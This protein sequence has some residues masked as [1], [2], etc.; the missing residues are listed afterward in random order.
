MV[1]RAQL[2][3]LFSRIRVV[4]PG[5]SSIRTPAER[6]SL[7]RRF[8]TFGRASWGT[9]SERVMLGVTHACGRILPWPIEIWRVDAEVVPVL[10][11][12]ITALPVL[13]IASKLYPMPSD[14]LHGGEEEGPIG[15]DLVVRFDEGQGLFAKVHRCG[16]RQA[17][18]REVPSLD[19]SQA[20]LLFLLRRVGRHVA[21][22]VAVYRRALPAAPHE[23]HVAGAGQVHHVVR[24]R[25]TALVGARSHGAQLWLLT[26]SV[27]CVMRKRLRRGWPE[28]PFS[29]IHRSISG[30][31][32][33]RATTHS[34]PPYNPTNATIM[35][36]GARRYISSL[37]GRVSSSGWS[38]SPV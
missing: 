4:V 37:T 15:V 28:S 29:A 38:H 9:R 12:L 22:R 16:R 1:R 2:S 34:E 33:A 25:N 32:S 5:T 8:Q 14:L 21:I 17:L 35:N 6:A 13:G 31:V 18:P 23:D 11:P 20:G 3:T 26:S 7:S 10:H 24:A 36:S 19:T 30:T 27:P